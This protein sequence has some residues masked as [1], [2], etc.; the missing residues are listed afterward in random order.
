MFERRLGVGKNLGLD[1]IRGPQLPLGVADGL[2]VGQFALDGG[3]FGCFC[4]LERRQF[5]GQPF[6]LF[7]LGP[8]GGGFVGDPGPQGGL[9]LGRLAFGFALVLGDALGPAPLILQAFGLFGFRCLLPR[10]PLR[11]GRLMSLA[12][13]TLGPKRSVTLGALLRRGGRPRPLCQ[14]GLSLGPHLLLDGVCGAAQCGQSSD[15]LA[16]G[17]HSH[18]E[19][20]GS[21][22]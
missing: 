4:G 13:F 20:L 5:V 14:F 10:Q 19:H 2:V 9:T 16:G 17:T 15:G 8:L 6:E 1:H 7:T 3:Q 21:R 12:L 18:A 11:L 22:Q